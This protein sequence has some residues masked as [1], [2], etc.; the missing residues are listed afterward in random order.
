LKTI[1]LKTL[2]T[3]H[4]REE[5]SVVPAAPGAGD[6]SASSGVEGWIFEVERR[7]RECEVK[8]VLYPCGEMFR[9]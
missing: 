2:I 1:S 9:G 5:G 4:I 7:I 6:A 8:I 3:G